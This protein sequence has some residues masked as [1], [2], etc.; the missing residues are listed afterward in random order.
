M[1]IQLRLYVSVTACRGFAPWRLARSLACVVIQQKKRMPS[2]FWK[3][4]DND[5]DTPQYAVPLAPPNAVKET[6]TTTTA[7]HSPRVPTVRTT[8]PSEDF[9]E[10]TNVISRFLE[11]AKPSVDASPVVGKRPLPSDITQPHQPR[12]KTHDIPGFVLRARKFHLVKSPSPMSS[13]FLIPKTF[14]QRHRKNRRKD[15]AIFV[16]RTEIVRKAKKVGDVSRLSSSESRNV[17]TGEKMDIPQLEKPRKRPNATA[18]ERR[19]R[20]ETWAKPSKLNEVNGNLAGTAENINEL[21]SQWNYE[22]AQLA[23]QLQGV[24]LEEIRASEEYAKGLSSDGKSKVKPKPP[25]PRQPRKEELANDSSEDDTMIDTINL[26]DDGDYVL[27][28]YVRSN[29][30]SFGAMEGAGSYHDWLHG[31]EHGNVGILV[32]EDEEEA[33]WEAFAKD[34]ESDPEWNSEEEDENGLWTESWMVR[35][36]DAISSGRL[37]WK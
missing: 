34:E 1:R 21:S 35:L 15:L 3:L 27:D 2:G 31:I 16:E 14:A 6:R 30:Q 26:D 9:N 7:F 10:Q 23:E 12:Q 11:S 13:P 18:A 33:L 8:L 24:A 25:K 28:T 5:N 17:D 29:A 36:T 4:V 19:W 20:T 37:L 22:S 32:I